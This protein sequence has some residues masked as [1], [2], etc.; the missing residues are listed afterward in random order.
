MTNL[1]TTIAEMKALQACEEAVAWAESVGLTEGTPLDILEKGGNIEWALWVL[2][3]LDKKLCV[4]LNCDF[5]EHVM[6]IWEKEYPDDRQPQNCI[7]VTRKWVLDEVTIEEVR[8]A[9]AAAYYTAAAAAANANAN[10]AYTAAAT[11]AAAYTAAAAAAYTAAAAAAYTAAYTA[12][13]A[14]AAYAAYA[15]VAANAAYAAYAAERQ[16]QRE[17]MIEVLKNLPEETK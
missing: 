9:N 2:W 7:A 1:K 11:A 17:H 4:S 8:A 16:W 3:H 6:P 10:A 5:A 13:T 12:A 15:A 14:V